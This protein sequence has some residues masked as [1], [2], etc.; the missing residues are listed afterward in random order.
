M[1]LRG[2][3][4][5]SLITG[6]GALLVFILS[7]FVFSQYG[8]HGKLTRDSAI[9][10][11]SGQQMAEGI[12]PF[13]SIFDHKGPLAPMLSGVGVYISHWL[14]TDDI[15][16]VRVTFFVLSL[17]TVVAIYLLAHSLFSS[18][19]LAFLTACTFL[20]FWGFGIYALSGPQAKTPML[21]FEVLALWLT[22]RRKWFWAGLC[23]SLAFLTWQPTLIY[24]FI[25]MLL[26]LL[27]SE[28]RK[29]KIKK[30]VSRNG[31]RIDPLALYKWIFF[32]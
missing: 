8:Y 28:G 30:C 6:L 2:K 12:P 14:H 19:S 29:L 26:A 31:R 21:L 15:L 13:A 11:Y 25:T 17:C 9:Y 24:S 7:A 23:G 20:N 16:T 32:V 10:L 4:R 5:S 27:Q 3:C 1:H 22:V 18:Y